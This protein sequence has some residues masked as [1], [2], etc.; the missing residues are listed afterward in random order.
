MLYV[1]IVLHGG[2]DNAHLVLEKHRKYLK[3][4]RGNGVSVQRHIIGFMTLAT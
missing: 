4:K 3:I 2:E 1:G